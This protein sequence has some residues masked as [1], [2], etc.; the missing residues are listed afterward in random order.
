MYLNEGEMDETG[1]SNNIRLMA[2][3]YNPAIN[4]A[5]LLLHEVFACTPYGPSGMWLMNWYWAKIKDT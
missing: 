1:S 3:C 4:L 5:Y 2:I